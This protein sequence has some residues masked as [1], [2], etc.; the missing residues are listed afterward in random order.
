M[1]EKD[2]P[3]E[4]LEMVWRLEKVAV[5]FHGK[6]IPYKQFKKDFTFILLKLVALLLNLELLRQEKGK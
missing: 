6:K 3:G 2:F 5:A 4:I 1:K